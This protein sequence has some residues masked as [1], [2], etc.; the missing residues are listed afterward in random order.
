MV[1]RE[2]SLNFGWDKLVS[3]SLLASI[4]GFSVGTDVADLDL[5]L[6]SLLESCVSCVGVVSKIGNMCIIWLS[7]AQIANVY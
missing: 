6:V 5:K 3:K 7:C 1:L 2:D 4:Q